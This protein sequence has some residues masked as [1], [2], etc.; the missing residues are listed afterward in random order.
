MAAPH[1]SLGLSGF[2]VHEALLGSMVVVGLMKF[3]SVSVV[4]QL[5]W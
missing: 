5:S 3:Y 4:C 2:E 1:Q